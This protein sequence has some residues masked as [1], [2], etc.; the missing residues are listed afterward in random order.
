MNLWFKDFVSK[1]HR[2]REA[3]HH[4]CLIFRLVGFQAGD[5]EGSVAFKIFR[6][7]GGQEFIASV[8]LLVS[9]NKSIPSLVYPSHHAF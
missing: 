1:V 7:N 3:G 6:E 9:G 5:D 2:V 8:N 4:S